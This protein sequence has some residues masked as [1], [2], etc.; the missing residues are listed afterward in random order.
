M[1]NKL[2]NG[3]AL[4]DAILEIVGCKAVV[5]GGCIRDYLLECN[6]N[7][8][9]MFVAFETLDSWTR[10]ANAFIKKFPDFHLLDGDLGAQYAKAVENVLYG[11]LEGELLG[12]KVNIVARTSFRFGDVYELVDSFD[13]KIL[14]H[15]YYRGE[16]RSTGAAL[17]DVAYRTATLHHERHVSQSIKRFLTFNERS[18][19][20]LSV[21][22]PFSTDSVIVNQI[23]EG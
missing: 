13:F 18:N 3:P 12:Y 9:D 7:D 11:V 15:W 6:P 8:I 14:Q 23:K 21:N 22:I 20:L 1:S 5:A 16:L 19:G 4:W 2:P 10:W 17:K